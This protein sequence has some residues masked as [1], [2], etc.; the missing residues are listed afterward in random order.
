MMQ[1]PNSKILMIE[2]NPGDADIVA[3]WLQDVSS[4]SFEIKVAGRLDQALDLLRRDNF[5]A[6]ILDLNLPDSQGIGT[7]DKL[8]STQHHG[9][10]I[11]YSGDDN[12]AVRQ[13]ALDAGAQDFIG[14]N[15]STSRLMA[16]S[17]LFTLE[18][19]RV[20]DGR[21][22]IERLIDASPDAILVTDPSGTI[23]FANPAA[24]IMF[25]RRAD[26]M[27]GQPVG[28]LPEPGRVSQMTLKRGG[29]S[30][31]AETRVSHVDWAGVPCHMVTLRDIT[32]RVAMEEKLRQ[33]QKMEALGHLTGG[34]AH[35]FNNLLLV[36]LANADMIARYH[37]GQSRALGEMTQ[38]IIKASEKAAAL[39]AR[40]LAFS[41]QQALQVTNV[42][43]NGLIQG[44]ESLIK[45]SLNESIQLQINLSPHLPPVSADRVQLETA[46]LNLC[47]NARDAM[48]AGGSLTLE[49][50]L[51]EGAEKSAPGFDDLVAERHIEIR[52]TDTG[53][54]MSPETMAQVFDPF[55]TTKG[56]GQGTGLGL[57]IIYG[58]IRQ[59]CGQVRITSQPGHGTSFSLILPVAV[60][61]DTSAPVK[62]P[63]GLV[64]GQ[65]QTVLV[66]EDNDLL[67]DTV[68]GQLRG[69]GYEVIGAENGPQALTLLASGRHVDLLF[70]DLLMP[71]GLNGHELANAVLDRWPAVRVLLT[72]GYADKVMRKPGIVSPADMLA[73]PYSYEDLSK[74][75][76]QTL[77]REGKLSSED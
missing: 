19:R 42:D 55:F 1:W 66:V 26:A 13:A 48:P 14:K 10:I 63:D 75:I 72:S 33:S 68:T 23:R 57:S 15:E 54:G 20:E 50:G 43:V 73:K 41:R 6:T 34:V 71:G 35:D 56:P 16:R 22:Q 32:Q 59:I 58:F 3:A 36:I 67:R 24:E 61:N 9:S 40:L 37:T 65:G 38:T 21:Q 70:S 5:E 49:T 76:W 18:R 46:I 28:F 60:A 47:V 12:P 27:I 11:V 25:G 39:T 2:D 51:Y 69:L 74:K 8:R 44:M 45:P 31:L 77:Q 4:D 64:M 53:T 7:L 30:F 52:V 62:A 17:I 29:T